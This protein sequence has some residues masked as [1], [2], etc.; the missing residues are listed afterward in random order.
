MF[1]GESFRLNIATFGIETLSGKRVAVRVPT[2]AVV[3][4]EAGPCPFDRSMILV[5]WNGRQLAMF[6]EDF[7]QR[8]EPVSKASKATGPPRSRSESRRVRLVRVQRQ[9]AG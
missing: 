7:Q 8:A 4:V 6:L 9:A 5:N 3:V 2:G 1:N